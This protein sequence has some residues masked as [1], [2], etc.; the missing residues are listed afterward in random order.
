MFR[1]C[2]PFPICLFLFHINPHYPISVIFIFG[3]PYLGDL[4]EKIGFKNVKI[5]IFLVF[6]GECG[7]FLE[8]VVDV[9]RK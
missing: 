6:F 8:Y 3:G 5:L 9:R 7:S 2:N 4:S 1:I